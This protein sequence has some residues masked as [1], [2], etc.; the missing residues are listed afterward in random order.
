MKNGGQGYII[1]RSPTRK[2]WLYLKGWSG[3]WKV[4]GMVAGGLNDKSLGREA[5]ST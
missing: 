2:N 4:R 5:G 1:T 3:N